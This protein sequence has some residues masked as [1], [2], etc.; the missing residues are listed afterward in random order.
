MRL[1]EAGPSASIIQ[2]YQDR[3]LL[4]PAGHKMIFRFSVFLKSVVPLQAYVSKKVQVL[5][6]PK[7]F[8]IEE[9]SFTDEAVHLC[10][11][12]APETFFGSL[13]ESDDLLSKSVDTIRAVL[14][15]FQVQFG[16]EIKQAGEEKKRAIY[17]VDI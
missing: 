8:T 15:A 14:K 10:S 5:N 12:T 16:D 6:A 11:V 3:P 17:A 4:T 1:T 13:P 9:A 7:P 2:K